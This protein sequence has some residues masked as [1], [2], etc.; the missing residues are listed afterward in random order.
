MAYS[1]E[2]DYIFTNHSRSVEV[3]CDKGKTMIKKAWKCEIMN[4]T[5]TKV[6]PAVVPVV[7]LE[8]T[9]EHRQVLSF[10]T[11]A[12]TCM[13]DAAHNLTNRHKYLNKTSDKLEDLVLLS[14]T[15]QE[16]TVDI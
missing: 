9:W 8:N 2:K 7:A 13:I 11:S 10:N 14:K 5:Y 6:L 4:F 1:M 12:V 16:T 3:Q 15:W